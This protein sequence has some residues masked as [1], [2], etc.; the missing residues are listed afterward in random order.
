MLIPKASAISFKWRF[1]M[2]DISVSIR[3]M[4]LFFDS[5]SM[6][7]KPGWFATKLLL[8]ARFRLFRCLSAPVIGGDFSCFSLPAICSFPAS[9][10]ECRPVSVDFQ[11]AAS[12]LLTFLGLAGAGRVCT[13]RT[14]GADLIVKPTHIPARVAI[15][16]KASRLNS[17]ILPFST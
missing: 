7:D 16:T 5:G 3:E 2:A 4:A 15:F 11:A 10:A 8:F 14:L 17:L 13:V 12:S 6:R 9:V 1:V